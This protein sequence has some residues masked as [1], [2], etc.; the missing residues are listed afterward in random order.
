MAA[1]ITPRRSMTVSALMY[2][3]KLESSS[4][5]PVMN[6]RSCM[7]MVSSPAKPTPQVQPTAAAMLLGWTPM[8]MHR[9]ITMVN[10]AVIK[11]TR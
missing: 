8:T 6:R 5:R 7:A 11:V 9:V 4:T 3:T 10:T 1:K 2:M